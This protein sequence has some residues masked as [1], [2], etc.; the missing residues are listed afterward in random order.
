MKAHK[1]ELLGEWARENGFEN[2][3]RFFHPQE[4]EKRR[5]AGVKRYNDKQRQKKEQQYEKRR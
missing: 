4:V 1:P 3:A 2:I 5:I